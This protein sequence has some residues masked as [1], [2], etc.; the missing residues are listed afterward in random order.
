[1]LAPEDRRAIESLFDR[2][3]D[4][5]RRNPDRDHEAEA[6]I[7][8]EG[9]RTQGAGYYM[10]QT[11]IVQERALEAAQQRIAELEQQGQSRGGFFDSIFGDGG[12]QN[13]R[14]TQTAPV[15]EQ[16]ANRGPWDRQR[17]AG[18]GGFLAGAAQTALG[19]TGG[20]LLGSAI[21]GMFGGGE[22]NAA[23]A[24]PEDMPADD[25]PADDG[26]GDLD[27]GGDF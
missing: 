25:M 19:V 9:A 26:G 4:V 7:Q 13:P 27:V 18:G 3:R 5:A 16:P 24:A 1:M 11:I 10:A 22:A 8:E 17:G 6:L 12:R 2:L 14:Q 15:P 21:A 20:V 23:E